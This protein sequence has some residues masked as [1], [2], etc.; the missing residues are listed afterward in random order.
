MAAVVVDVV[1]ERLSVLADTADAAA[2]AR[3]ALVVLAKVLR[4]RQHS[5]EELQRHNLHAVVVHLVDASHA[6][7]LDYAQ[8]SEIFLSEGHPEAGTLDGRI[9]EHERFKLLVVEQIAVARADIRI[10][11]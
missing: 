10:G 1:G 5:L 7:I 6:D 9:V 8:V 11:E 3:L 4:V 2:D